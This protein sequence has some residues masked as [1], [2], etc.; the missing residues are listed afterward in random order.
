MFSGNSRNKPCLIEQV[1]NDIVDSELEMSRKGV[2]EC[3]FPLE[4]SE[5]TYLLEGKL[6]R[7]TVVSEWWDDSLANAAGQDVEFKAQKTERRPAWIAPVS[8][9]TFDRDK[10]RL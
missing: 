5:L 1:M 8:T 3:A 9:Q 7:T 2:L 10:Y 4:N 6:T